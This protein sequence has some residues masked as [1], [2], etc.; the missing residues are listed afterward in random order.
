[1]NGFLPDA[2]SEKKQDKTQ[3]GSKLYLF[4]RYLLKLK[5]QSSD[6]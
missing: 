5:A 2:N 1:M 3:K 6:S 4:I